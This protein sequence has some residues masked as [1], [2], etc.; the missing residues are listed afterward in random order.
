MFY[1]NRKLI[2]HKFTTYVNVIRFDLEYKVSKD[3][4]IAFKS[5]LRRRQIN[6]IQEAKLFLSCYNISPPPT[7]VSK[8]SMKID[9][10]I[11]DSFEIQF[12]YVEINMI[13]YFF[14]ILKLSVETNFIENCYIYLDSS[15]CKKDFTF[16]EFLKEISFVTPN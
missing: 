12:K 16:I 7:L 2:I 8:I 5:I 14:A 13:F 9:K 3:N 15:N 10:Y 4:F 6:S 11:N 1:P